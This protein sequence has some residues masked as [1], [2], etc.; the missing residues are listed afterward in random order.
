MP[1]AN[2]SNECVHKA[3]HLLIIAI[4]SGKLRAAICERLDKK[5]GLLKTCSGE[6][7][8]FICVKCRV[9]KT[10]KTNHRLP[11]NVALPSVVPRWI[12]VLFI[13]R[14][15]SFPGVKQAGFDAVC[16]RLWNTASGWGAAAECGEL[17]PASYVTLWQHHSLSYLSSA[18]LPPYPLFSFFYT[19]PTSISHVR[20]GSR[21]PAAIGTLN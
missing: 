21:T 12:F 5:N 2:S 9:A 4:F 14:L 1:C 11:S 8:T 18:P 13:N 3:R 19:P 20:T 7:N 15:S 17:P 10:K 16:V 6:K